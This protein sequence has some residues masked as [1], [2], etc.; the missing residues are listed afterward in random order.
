MQY[1][2]TF[3]ELLINYKNLSYPGGIYIEGDKNTNFQSSKYWILS[4][5][6]EKDEFWVETN[7]GKIPESLK[8][9]NVKPFLDVG[10]F[11]DIIENKLEHNSNLALE[12]IKVF[13]E[14]IEYYLDNDDFWD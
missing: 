5:K 14:A 3:S 11:Q 8:D 13:I 6:E 2:Q 4:D 9:F 10:T 12:N 1:Y 7:F